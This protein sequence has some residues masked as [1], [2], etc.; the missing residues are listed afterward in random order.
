MQS[1]KIG[2]LATNDGT[3]MLATNNDIPVDMV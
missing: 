1:K 3:Q 2:K